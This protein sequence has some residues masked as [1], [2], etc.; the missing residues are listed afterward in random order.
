M[1]P[2]PRFVIGWKGGFLKPGL[3]KAVKIAGTGA[4]ALVAAALA[5]I[6]FIALPCPPVESLR[7]YK[8][9]Q[10]IL[11]LDREGKLLARLAPEER[12][13]VPL[14][15]V[16]PKLVG[17]FVA[18]EDQRF[19]E[20]HGIDWHRVG[21]ALW[22]DLRTFSPREGSSTITMQLAR[23]VF[24][25]RL[26]RA[27]T[28]RRK[29]AEMIVARRIEKQFSKQQILELY[30][31]QIYLG[32]GYY[33]VEAASHGYF[34]RSARELTVPQASLLAALP[35]APSNYDPRR[36]PDAALKRRNLVL[37]QM[38]KFKVIDA[39]EE[40]AARKSKLR[41]RPPEEEGGA[42]WFV[43]EVRR[44]LHER[45]GPGAETQGLRV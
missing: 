22:R 27:R 15:A 31:N 7:D 9:Q 13:V 1:N 42:P 18:V 41:L 29:L 28:L 11:V 37:G 35:K 26:T 44:E 25:D 36:Y 30:L 38:T 23:N 12:I 17:A 5:G 6:A 39:R 43:A 20:H 14:S 3:R 34:G 10:A 19:F 32:N 16:S 40:A 4:G 21:G 24:P 45:F 33:G 2:R 8:P